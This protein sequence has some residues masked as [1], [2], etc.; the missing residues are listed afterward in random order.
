MRNATNM[1][2]CVPA[3]A[4][5]GER[6]AGR[7]VA[8]GRAGSDAGSREALKAPQSVIARSEAK[9]RRAG[10][11]A[12]ATYPPSG[13]RSRSTVEIGG[14]VGMIFQRPLMVTGP[15]GIGAPYRQP[16]EKREIRPASL[17]DRRE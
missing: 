2:P 11:G 4:I 14:L 17:R 16:F 7:R 9:N 1:W 6:R 10:K 12:Q 5:A 13:P 8:G 3:H 15:G